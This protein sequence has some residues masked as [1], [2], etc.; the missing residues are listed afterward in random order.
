[1]KNNA[2]LREGLSKNDVDYCNSKT[3]YTETRNYLFG[4]DNFMLLQ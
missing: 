1:M 4:K 3:S 2:N